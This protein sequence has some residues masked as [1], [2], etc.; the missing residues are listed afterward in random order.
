M[1]KFTL[2]TKKWFNVVTFMQAAA[3][4]VGRPAALAGREAGDETE[5]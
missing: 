1:F 5:G 4:P 2:Y 3:H